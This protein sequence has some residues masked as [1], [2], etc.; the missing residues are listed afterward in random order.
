MPAGPPTEV[1]RRPA[2]DGHGCPVCGFRRPVQA[3][4]MRRRGVTRR[5]NRATLG[6]IPR[7]G[8]LMILLNPNRHASHAPTH[9]RA[10]SWRGRSPS[11]R[12]RACAGSRRRTATGSG[13]PTCSSSSRA[14]RCW[15]PCSPGRL[16]RWP[17]LPLGQLAQQRAQRDPGLLRAH[18]WYTWQVTILGL[19][20]IWM[21]ANE[22]AK[23]KAADFLRQGEVF[24]FGCPRSSTAQTSTRPR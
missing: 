22:Q 24:A 12:P 21:S 16:R 14:S 9:G 5:G 19:G 8:A 6:S 13:T 1:L 4:R 18:Y 7:R 10:R 11:S 15:Q 20:P 2:P 23:R 3:R 17:G